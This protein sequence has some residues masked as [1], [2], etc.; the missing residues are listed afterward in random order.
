[1]KLIETHETHRER[2][3]FLACL[4]LNEYLLV[5]ISVIINRYSKHYTKNHYEHSLTFARA[6]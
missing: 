4:C 3:S 2:A 6:G 5:K 1:M